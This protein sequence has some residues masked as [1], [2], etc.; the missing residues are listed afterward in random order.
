MDRYQVIFKYRLRSE[1]EIPAQARHGAAAE[2]GLSCLELLSKLRYPNYRKM[3]EA[4][5]RIQSGARGSDTW[6]NYC[7]AWGRK[8]IMP[9]DWYGEGTQ[10][11]FEGLAVMVPSQWEKWLTQI[12]GDY[13][14]LPPVEK[15]VSHH[16]A[17]RI[18]LDTPW[19]D[20][21]SK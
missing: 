5:E 4:R 14:C 12:Y 8:E 13:M 16:Y 7:G 18:A 1:M 17:E 3:L 6:V 2:A 19:K 15:R 11:T 20:T 10:L 9:A 21:T